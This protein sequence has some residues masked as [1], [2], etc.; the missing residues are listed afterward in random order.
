MSKKYCI[1][2]ACLLSFSAYALPTDDQRNLYQQTLPGVGQGQPYPYSPLPAEV[3]PYTSTPQ[4]YFTY[5]SAEGGC[6]CHKEE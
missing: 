1:A 4:S 2:L 6:S 3:Y 5:A